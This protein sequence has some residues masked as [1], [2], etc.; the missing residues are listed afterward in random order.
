LRVRNYAAPACFLQV[1]I[2]KAQ[3]LNL[4]ITVDNCC[5]ECQSSPLGWS[6]VQWALT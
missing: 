5:G 2:V 3:D 1:Q 6:H 4:I